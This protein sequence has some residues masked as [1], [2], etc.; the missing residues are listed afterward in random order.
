[1]FN[2]TISLALIFNQYVNPVALD[3]LQWKYYLVY[4]CWLAFELVFVYFCKLFN[5]ILHRL[6]IHIRLSV[7]IETK[8]RTLE[9]TAALFDGEDAANELAAGA[10]AQVNDEKHDGS[11]HSDEKTKA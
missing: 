6:E 10:V 4:V 11:L 2:F 7:V 3:K 1:M 8:N 5:L 9:E